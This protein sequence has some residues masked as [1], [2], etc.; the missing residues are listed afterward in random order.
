MPA[1]AEFPITAEESAKETMDFSALRIIG[2]LSVG[3]AVAA[4]GLCL[5]RELCRRSKFEHRT[6]YDFYSH[7][8]KQ[9][10]SEFGYGI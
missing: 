8:D 7:I 3:M 5:G 4:L 6:P 10:T 9:Q 2:W 1:E